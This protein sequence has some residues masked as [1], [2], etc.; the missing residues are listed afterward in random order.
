MTTISGKTDKKMTIIHED[1]AII[2]VAKPAGMLV[3]PDHW[4]KSKP[5]LQ[6]LLQSSMAGGKIYVVHRLDEDTSGV[7]VLAKTPPAH[8]HLCQQLLNRQMIKT[9]LAVVD[10]Q[11]AADGIIDRPLAPD[12]RK[13]GRMIVQKGGK[14][15]VTEFQVLERFRDFSVLKV[16]PR[17]GRTHQIRVHLQAS[18]HPLAIDRFYGQREAIY[19][20]ELK[21]HY[22]LKVDEIERPLI[23]RLTLHAL[24]LC[25]IH[26]VNN[27]EI[28]LTAEIPKDLR[29]LLNS[30]QKYQ[31][32]PSY[33]A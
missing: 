15:S 33:S 27:Q 20:S 30:L 10:G 18:G 2:A 14:A 23:G 25:F 12:P 13:K 22:R 24:T 11:V 6:M 26:P 7:V 1:E 21:P 19:L 4:D 31:A 3:I 28:L 9:Y 5:N 32:L 17:T 8:R 16:Q 29:A